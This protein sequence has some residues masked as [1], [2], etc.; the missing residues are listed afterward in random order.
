MTPF[1][2]WLLEAKHYRTNLSV[3]SWSRIMLFPQCWMLT[4][5]LISIYFGT[6]LKR[7]YLP[8]CHKIFTVPRGHP[9]HQHIKNLRES[10]EVIFRRR[11]GRKIGLDPCIWSL[12]CDV[13]SGINVRYLGTVTSLVEK[14]PALGYLQVLWDYTFCYSRYDFINHRM[15]A[16][17]YQVINF[18]QLIRKFW[19]RSGSTVLQN[20][21]IWAALSTHCCKLALHGL[22]ACLLS[23]LQRCSSLQSRRK[24]WWRPL[25]L[26]LCKITK[27]NIHLRFT[28]CSVRHLINTHTSTA[29]Q[30]TFQANFSSALSAP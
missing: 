23:G 14:Q 3:A 18:W 4:L 15:L 19:W 10:D 26:V 17:W 8:Y 30:R 22:A 2:M 24:Q 7:N 29:L 11:V 16:R 5:I 28:I 21:E 27:E 20:N 25:V 12:C 9:W 6:F 13:C 1:D